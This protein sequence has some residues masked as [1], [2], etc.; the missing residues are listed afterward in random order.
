MQRLSKP[1]LLSTRFVSGARKPK[2]KTFTT[3]Q[4]E[5]AN[6]FAVT[7]FLQRYVGLAMIFATKTPKKLGGQ[8]GL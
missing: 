3:K 2:A 4:E 6:G 5:L 7:S 8:V 1:I